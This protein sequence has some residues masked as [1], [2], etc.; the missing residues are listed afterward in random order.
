P[1][2]TVEHHSLYHSLVPGEPDETP[3]CATVADRVGHAFSH[4]PGQDGI[5]VWRKV[6]SRLLDHTLHSCRFK[7]LPCPI[8]LVCEGWLPITRDGFAHL[9]ERRARH[10]FGLRACLGAPRGASG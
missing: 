5:E 4:G 9:A 6:P 2:A 10:A 3:L 7:Q 1:A 8:Q